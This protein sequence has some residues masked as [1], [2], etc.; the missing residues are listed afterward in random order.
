MELPKVDFQRLAFALLFPA[1]ISLGYL[2]FTG[3]NFFTPNETLLAFGASSAMP[4]NAL[5][6]FLVHAWYHHLFFNFAVLLS[7]GFVAF[8]ALGKKHFLAL[9]FSSAVISALVAIII[10]P[11]FAFVGASAVASTLL[12]VAF[13][14]RPKQS[15]YAILASILMI[16][17]LLTP[18]TTMVFASHLNELSGQK[19]SL[20]S[21]YQAVLQQATIKT[22]GDVNLAKQLPEIKEAETRLARAEKVIEETLQSEQ[23]SREMPVS[24]FMHAFGALYGFA[25]V[26]VFKRE[27]IIKGIEFLKKA[28]SKLLDKE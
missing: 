8:A 1:L 19:E 20:E 14:T 3:L 16:S 2:F 27:E 18:F 13:V 25:Y 6:Y 7:F 10:F 17:L 12:A 28:A 24:N 4:Q 15:L 9:S 26:F 22:G 5:I 21:D 11:R 23:R